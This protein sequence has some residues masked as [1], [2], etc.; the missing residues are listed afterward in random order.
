L[1]NDYL[2]REAK[3]LKSTCP[4]GNKFQFSLATTPILLANMAIR[5]QLRTR[6]ACIL[7]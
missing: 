2:Y 4:V 5:G 3:Q 1:V 6:R 7:N